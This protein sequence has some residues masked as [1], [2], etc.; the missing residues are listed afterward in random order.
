MG[1]G[2]EGLL[3]HDTGEDV[4]N[5]AGVSS[6]GRREI[7]VVLADDDLGVG[8]ALA[9]LL[10]QEPDFRVVGQAVTGDDAVA[11]ASRERAALVLTDV[12]MP[13]G[14]PDLVRRLRALD[15][16]PVVVGLSA[17]ADPGTWSR[18]LAAGASA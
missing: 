18:M 3:H 5:G 11:V 2:R 16:A 7:T 15:H 9:A 14:G 10:G 6:P 17:Q 12:R 1:T 4:R 13:G 8:L